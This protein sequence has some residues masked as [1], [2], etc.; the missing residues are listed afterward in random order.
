MGS[1]FSDAYLQCN[2]MCDNA[3]ICALW[4]SFHVIKPDLV[5]GKTGATVI[6]IGYKHS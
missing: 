6:R 1:H 5:T 3:I 2:F 4:W